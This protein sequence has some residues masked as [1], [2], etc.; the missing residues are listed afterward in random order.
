MGTIRHK[1]MPRLSSK[2]WIL[3]LVVLTQLVSACGGTTP[4]PKEPAVGGG[5]EPDGT[6]TQGLDRMIVAGYSTSELVTELET[7][8]SLLLADEFEQAA[9]A[10][11]RLMK[12]ASDPEL[13][14]LATFDSGW[15]YEGL[16]KR[17]IAIER[18]ETLAQKYPKQGVTKNALVRLT[19]LYGYLERWPALEQAA[20]QLLA[21]G[22]DL[23]VMNRIEGHSAKGLALVEQGKID[24]GRVA[25]SKAQALIDQHGF[26]RAGP[27]PERDL[28]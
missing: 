8:R 27:P 1:G 24:A 16:G 26:G 12:L 22:A 17:E 14:A 6:V 4:G 11:D 13:I 2:A 19:R 10:F 25:L 21:R 18:F 9:K 23:P 20:D 7:A 3:P 15:A 28:N 5:A